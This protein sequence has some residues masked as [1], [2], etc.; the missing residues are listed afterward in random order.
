[1][2]ANDINQVLVDMI[3]RERFNYTG[4]DIIEYI[5]GCLCLRKKKELKEA[6]W[7]KKHFLFSKGQEKL[8]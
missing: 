6:E 4:K 7:G 1:M 3:N 8:D 2:T 5:F